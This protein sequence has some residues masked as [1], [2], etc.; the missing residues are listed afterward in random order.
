MKRNDV[1][2]L[3]KIDS[4][5]KLHKFIDNYKAEHDDESS[6]L[7]LILYPPTKDVEAAV[8]SAW[9]AEPLF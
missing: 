7:E 5:D 8:A 6:E 4:W 3:T 1:T 9:E 2:D